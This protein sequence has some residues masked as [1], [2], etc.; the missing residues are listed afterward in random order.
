MASFRD[1]PAQ[2]ARIARRI[3]RGA[4][5]TASWSSCYAIIVRPAMSCLKM[6]TIHHGKP[7]RLASLP[8]MQ[9]AS[10]P[11]P[12]AT[13]HLVAHLIKHACSA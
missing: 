6:M 2:A 11:T 8:A 5:R 7:H 1:R 12:S 9:R 4:S 13:V 10:P 3:R